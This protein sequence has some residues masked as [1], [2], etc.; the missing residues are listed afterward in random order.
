M[1]KALLASLFVF[2]LNALLLLEILPF[3]PAGCVLT[4]LLAGIGTSAAHYLFLRELGRPA[5]K[6][7]LETA[8]FFIAVFLLYS[9]G[10][11]LLVSRFLL[12]RFEP[13][14]VAGR[15]LIMLTFLTAWGFFREA[16]K[17]LA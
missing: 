7:R 3:R 10:V 6:A 4:L 13:F 2:C 11:G 5:S 8:A 1:G 15:T 14:D 16:K 12:G 17:N 9:C